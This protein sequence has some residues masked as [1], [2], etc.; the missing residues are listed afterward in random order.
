MHKTGPLGLWGAK[1]DSI[2]TYTK[3]LEE[4]EKECEEMSKGILEGKGHK[5]APLRRAA[6]V[7]FH[8]AKHATMA[9]QCQ[10]VEDPNKWC[11]YPR[12]HVDTDIR[13]VGGWVGG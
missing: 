2:D 11:G 10:H 1:V 8:S 9:A 13:W 5:G 7:T 3:E 4:V 6:F 12:G